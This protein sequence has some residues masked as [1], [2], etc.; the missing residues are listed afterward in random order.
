MKAQI[1][2]LRVLVEGVVIVVSI[3][4]AFGLQAWPLTVSWH[5]SSQGG[6]H[7]SNPLP[8]P[9]VMQ[10]QS[11]APLLLG[12]EA[13]DARPVMVVCRSDKEIER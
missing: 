1:P 4:L 8:M 13:W 7:A 12:E 9:E 3:L 5:I 10:G 11:L 2:W 6:C